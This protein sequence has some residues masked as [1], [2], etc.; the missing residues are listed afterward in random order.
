MVGCGLDNWCA[1]QVAR[2]IQESA[3]VIFV[4]LDNN[5]ISSAGVLAIAKGVCMC[6]CV[7]VC[8]CVYICVCVCV[9]VCVS[10]AFSAV[11]NVATSLS[12]LFQRETLTAICLISK[13]YTTTWRFK[14]RL[15]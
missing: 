8:V 12:T 14:F 13:R 7:C 11:G 2:F 15:K 6:V 9:C 3:T 4:N 5:Q 1:K 10:L